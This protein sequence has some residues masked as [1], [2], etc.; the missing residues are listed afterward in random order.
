MRSNAPQRSVKASSVSFRAEPQ[1]S[2]RQAIAAILS[3]TAF[4]Y[5]YEIDI[6]LWLLDE[7]I[8]DGVESGYH[9]L[10]ADQDDETVGYVCYGPITMTENRYDLYWIAVKKDRQGDGIGGELLRKAEKDM[11]EKGGVFLYVE[12]SGRED[13]RPTLEFYEKHKYQRVACI[14]DFYKDGDD[15]I[16]FAKK[17]S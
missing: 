13:Y 12:T 5:S 7:G 1:L 11:V 3:S 8:R 16:I 9:F 10:F 4:F 17:L 6:A 14:P 2:D 15:K